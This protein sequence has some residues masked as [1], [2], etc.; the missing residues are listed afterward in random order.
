MVISDLLLGLHGTVLFTWGGFLLVALFG[1][2][3]RTTS[4]L[5]RVPLGAAGAALIFFLVSNGGVWLEGK[6]YPLTGQGLLDAYT[7]P[8]PSCVRH[9]WLT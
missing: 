1:T 3:W 4:N 8:F 5:F 2:R 6:L 7:L 9:S